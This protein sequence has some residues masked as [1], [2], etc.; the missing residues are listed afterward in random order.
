MAPTPFPN[1][2]CQESTSIDNRNQIE[3]ALTIIVLVLINFDECIH[4]IYQ[5]TDI[6]A[7]SVSHV[8][9]IREEPVTLIEA[10]SCG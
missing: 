3:Y 8:M 4:V 5:S 2:N 6:Y 9:V 1:D 10:H 7:L